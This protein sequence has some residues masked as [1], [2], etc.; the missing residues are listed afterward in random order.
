M[1][2]LL[3]EILRTGRVRTVDQT[4]EIPLDS[5]VTA[6]VGEFLQGLIARKKPHTTL[7]I[8]LAHGVSALFICEALRKCGG[9]KHITIDPNQSTQFR[10]IGINHLRLAG[11]GDLVEL[12]ELPSHRVLP[13]LEASG[14]TV[15]FA[16]IDGWHTFDYALTDFFHVD[17]VLAEGGIVV[18]DDAFFP[19]VHQACRYV[20][21]NRSYRPLACSENLSAY[22]P[23]RGARLLRWAARKST[24][25][26]KILKPKFV[27]PDEQLGFTPDCRCVAFEKLSHDRRAWADH[28]EF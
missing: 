7:E 13:Q 12:H 23:S 18:F 19:G 16:F 3:E 8:G 17:R 15:E 25:A 22:Q 6:D 10:G 27:V 28:S 9:A 14:I 4:G 5:A 20:A 24:L 2:P 1:V 11:F 26:K 21:T